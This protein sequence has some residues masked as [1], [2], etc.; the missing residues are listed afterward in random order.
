MITLQCSYIIVSLSFNYVLQVCW[1]DYA[2]QN[3]LSCIALNNMSG[4]IEQLGF[5]LD[6][7]RK[8]DIS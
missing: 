4:D 6:F 1:I 2:V 3:K 8:F 7:S 5:M